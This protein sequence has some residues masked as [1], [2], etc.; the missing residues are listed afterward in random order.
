MRCQN[1]V[2]LVFSVMRFSCKLLKSNNATSFAMVYISNGKF[3]KDYKLTTFF[4][5]LKN[6]T[7]AQNT[8][9]TVD[10]EKTSRIPQDTKVTIYNK[11]K[12]Y[13]MKKL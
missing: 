3:Y 6:W 9:V 12:L 1:F 7:L 10:S 4:L 8:R 2:C 11:R 5:L 13:Y